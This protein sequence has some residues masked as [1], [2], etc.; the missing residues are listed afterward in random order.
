MLMTSATTSTDTKEFFSLL[1]FSPGGGRVGGLF[2]AASPRLKCSNKHN[3]AQT[4]SQGTVSLLQAAVSNL[5]LHNKLLLR[6]LIHLVLFGND[7]ATGGGCRYTFYLVNKET[8]EK[9]L[10]FAAILREKGRKNTQ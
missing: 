9:C 7:A 4:Y 1:F 2:K 10:F 5:H 8:S 6:L 3:L